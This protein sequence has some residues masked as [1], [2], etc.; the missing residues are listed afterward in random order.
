M[1][2]T[3]CNSGVRLTRR[4]LVLNATATGYELRSLGPEGL[5]ELTALH[6]QL[7]K[8][9]VESGGAANPLISGGVSHVPVHCQVEGEL[10]TTKTPS[11]ISP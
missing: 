10:S 4:G 1:P 6:G 3:R 2:P 7:E 9:T 11:Q 8:L 5:V